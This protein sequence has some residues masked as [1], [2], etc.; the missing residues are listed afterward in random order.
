M[1]S[2]SNQEGLQSPRA[3]EMTKLTLDRRCRRRVTRVVDAGG[4]AVNVD[5]GSWEPNRALCTRDFLPFQFGEEIGSISIMPQPS[6]SHRKDFFLV[7]CKTEL[8]V[9]NSEN[10]FT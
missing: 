4:N 2:L 10:I 7:A 3:S 6:L 8:F 1:P 5:F 9:G